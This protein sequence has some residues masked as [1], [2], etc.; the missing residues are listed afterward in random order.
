MAN[1]R[2]SYIAYVCNQFSGD[3]STVTLDKSTGQVR[4]EARFNIGGNIMPMAISPDRRHLFVVR[5]N[6]P[7]AII[8]FEISADGA[9]IHKGE[10]RSISGYVHI[11]VDRSGRY[12]LGVSHN[13]HFIGLHPIVDGFV[14]PPVIV[15]AAGQYPHGAA[16]SPTNKLVLVTSLGDDRLLAYDFDA[17]AGRLEERRGGAVAFDAG[18]EPR[19]VK[20]NAS[21]ASVFV[22]GELAGVLERIRLD[23]WMGALHRLDAIDIRT[24]QR[25]TPVASAA[26]IALSPDETYLYVSERAAN[27]IVCVKNDKEMGGFQVVDRVQ[28]APEP[29]SISLSP[30]GAFLLAGGQYSGQLSVFGVNPENGGLHAYEA[31]SGFE[32][33]AWVQ[34]LDYS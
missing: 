11:S 8:S 7:A 14:E 12:L 20:I 31:V 21:G 2:A 3:L 28:T 1:E 23:P 24:T 16:F 32:G 15:R 17:D 10:I 18:F 4:E 22:I 27:Q 30:D 34:F 19:H 25:Q 26:D 29:R 33:P 13:D 6:E 5:R 9:L